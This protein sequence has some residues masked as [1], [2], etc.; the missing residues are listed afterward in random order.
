MD[1][2]DLKLDG[3]WRIA[4]ASSKGDGRPRWTE[5]YVYRLPAEQLARLGTK[6][7][8]VAEVMGKSNLPGERTKRRRIAAGTLERALDWIDDT[9]LGAAAKA[10]AREW[11]IENGVPGDG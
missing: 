11:A 9:D 6:R 10:G 5:I 1:A 7:E 3:S 4:A 2:N 8:F